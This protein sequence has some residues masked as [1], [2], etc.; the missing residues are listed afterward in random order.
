MPKSNRNSI[1]VSS[2]SNMSGLRL[3]R[4]KRIIRVT[5]NQNWVDKKFLSSLHNKLSCNISHVIESIL[6]YSI[7]VYAELGRF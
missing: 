4:E 2:S 6:E 7:R 5:V 3:L 1:A